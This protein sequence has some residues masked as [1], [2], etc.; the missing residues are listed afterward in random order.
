ML[1]L[2]CMYCMNK[3]YRS[4]KKNKYY[5]KTMSILYEHIKCMS[6]KYFSVITFHLYTT[7]DKKGKTKETK[8]ALQPLKGKKTLK[9][10]TL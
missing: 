5:Y 3:T 10:E 7:T 4:K 2:F 8:K 6:V 9:Y 1:V